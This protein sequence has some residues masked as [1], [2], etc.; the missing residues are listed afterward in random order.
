AL[1]LLAA[2]AFGIQFEEQLVEWFMRG[3]DV[4]TLATGTGRTDLWHLLITE[5]APKSP[6]LGA[7]YLMLS[8]HGRFEHAGAA[9]N[10]AHNSFV[11]ALVS[12]GIP[13]CMAVLSIVLLPL[14]RARRAVIHCIPE[15][16]ESRIM[17]FALM[18]VIGITSVTGFGI[19]GHPNVAMLFHYGLYAMCVAPLP[20]KS[21]FKS[22]EPGLDWSPP[23]NLEGAP[24]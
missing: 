5:Q 19:A 13:G 23:A 12:T 4:E 9:W 18:V 24:S 17:V 3:D 20:E 16:R 14:W 21:R 11:F 10:N 2:A 7:G 6:L 15:E 22:A 1:L 8:E